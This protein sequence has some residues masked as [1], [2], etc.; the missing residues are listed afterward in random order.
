MRLSTLIVIAI[1]S[2]HFINPVLSADLTEVERQKIEKA[3][4]QKATV[5]PKKTRRLLVT[6]FVNIK[7]RPG[8]GH[9]SIP[10]GNLALELMGRSTG[11]YEMVVNNDTLMFRPE[12]LQQFD[13]VCFNNTTG[14]LFTDPELRKSLLEFIKSGKGFIGFHAA[15][16]TM[17]QYPKYDYWPEFGEMLGGFEDGGH[18]WTPEE[19]M[20][21]KLDDPDHPLNAVFGGKGFKIKDE[22]F[23]FRHGYTRENLHILLAIDA[24]DE[25]FQRRRILPERMKDRDLALS[26]IR[27]YG[28]GRVFYCLLGHNPDTFSNPA[29]LRH[30]LDGIQFALGDYD[31]NATPSMKPRTIEN[32][33]NEIKTYEYD[34]SRLSLTH[35]S[36]LIREA[37]R[38][39]EQ[40]KEIEGHLLK[41]LQSQATLAAKEYVCR[42]LRIIGSENAVPVL[43]TLLIDAET[44]EMAL[45]AL[46][47]MPYASIDIVLIEALPKTTGRSK[48]GII[49]A[50]ANRRCKQSVSGLNPLV[51]DSDQQVAS[52]AIFALGEIGGHE[53]AIILGKM[54]KDKNNPL[55]LKILEAY[56]R[57][58]ACFLAEG[59]IK[60]AQ[61][62]YQR[63]YR[64]NEPDLIRIEAFRGLI[65]ADHENAEKMVVVVLASKDS[66]LLNPALAKAR[67]LP[68]EE[69]TKALVMA[70]PGFDALGQIQTLSVLADRGDLTALPAVINGTQHDQESVRIAALNALGKLGDAS[71]VMLLAEKAASTEGAEKKAARENLYRMKGARIDH[72][73]LT[74]LHQGAANI[75]V[76]LIRSMGMRNVSD[77]SEI[78][79]KTA[80]DADVK[81]RMESYK[82]LAILADP[83]DLD[84]LLDLLMQVETE[85]ER[86]EVV[87]TIVTV[88]KKIT[89][90]HN[91]SDVIITRFSLSEDVTN[92]CSLL[93]V[94]GGIGNES[95]LQVF[96]QALT[97]KNEDL[98]YCALRALASWP[99]PNPVLMDELYEIVRTSD[100]TVNKTMALRAYIRLI[101][102]GS[103]F[104]VQE[105]IKIYRSA[106]HLASES[107]EKKM[108]LSGLG[109]V[110]CYD[111]LEM[112]ASCLDEKSLSA[113]AESAIIAIA[114]ETLGSYPQETRRILEKVRKI[115]EDDYRRRQIDRLLTGEE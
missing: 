94:L 37:L 68:G 35:L 51:S 15:G 110:P 81:V 34:S 23:Q 64:L 46:E 2:C 67:E 3:I 78:L 114:P 62:S 112:A 14:V 72:E 49:N 17:C 80:I 102:L 71:V 87:K 53:A 13:A 73:I 77:A 66:L 44:S 45:Y 28:K 79:L 56:L 91:Q 9:T 57:C 65:A 99:Y 30:F 76:E 88:A 115:T 8:Y 69:I 58:A 32:I 98:I 106:M 36:D 18:P 52:A 38:S 85:N 1:F 16:A 7:D 104:S 24:G 54:I 109:K 5:Q 75:Q 63:L 70:L 84:A 50:L 21:I 95:S 31:V 97:D 29:I 42:E 11:A 59:K 43:G 40:L 20:K 82:S 19:Y 33:L 39:P 86:N 48:I 111:A 93:L 26:W 107:N 74:R 27:N 92:K 6:N 41:F 105:T 61:A 55:R 60:D 108:I 103:D 113:E 100:N 101:G 83:E 47:P 89:D 96:K 25:D 4:P 90:E 12:N 22:A 10:H